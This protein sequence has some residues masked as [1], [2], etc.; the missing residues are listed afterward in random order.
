MNKTAKEKSPQIKMSSKKHQKYFKGSISKED[1]LLLK[2]SV[3]KLTKRT[4]NLEKQNLKLHD[5]IKVIK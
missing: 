1:F 2:Q 4:E 3:L 5:E